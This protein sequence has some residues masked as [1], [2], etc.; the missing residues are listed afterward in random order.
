MRQS[1]PSSGFDFQVRLL[2][3]FYGFPLSDVPGEGVEGAGVRPPGA[4]EGVI[5]AA[6]LAALALPAP[7]IWHQKVIPP[8]EPSTR[9]DN[10]E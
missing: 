2:K 1:R 10:W 3:T 5:A 8:E 9:Y 4:S 7:G 6:A